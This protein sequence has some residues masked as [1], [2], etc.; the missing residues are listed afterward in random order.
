[1]TC[2]QYSVFTISL[3]PKRSKI[4]RAELVDAQRKRIRYVVY[5]RNCK[6]GPEPG[7]CPLWWM[8]WDVWGIIH[9]T[10]AVTS[11][12][13][14]IQHIS[15]LY[16]IRRKWSRDF[17]NSVNSRN[18]PILAVLLSSYFSRAALKTLY[19]SIWTAVH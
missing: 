10:L 17:A 8:G 9:R 19:K 13:F 1:M 7:P 14:M 4:K 18:G 6:R 11:S 12:S 15:K 16:G 5:S 3:G 2:V